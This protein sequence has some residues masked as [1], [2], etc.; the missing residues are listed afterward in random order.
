MIVAIAFL[1]QLYMALRL[2]TIYGSFRSLL[3]EV[4]EETRTSAEFQREV[5]NQLRAAQ[6][7]LHHID[8]KLA[9]ILPPDV[10]V[11]SISAENL[12]VGPGPTGGHGRRAA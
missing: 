12:V 7:F 10:R 9:S 3:S 8:E 2:R 5:V 6:V 4:A 1:S 11:A